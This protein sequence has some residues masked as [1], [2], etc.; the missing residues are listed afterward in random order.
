MTATTAL[1]CVTLAAVLVAMVGWWV[2]GVRRTA[3]RHL[4]RQLTERESEAGAAR[5]DAE[6]LGRELEA[7]RAACDLA[8]QLRLRCGQVTAADILPPVEPAA[9]PTSVTVE[10]GGSSVPRETYSA[11]DGGDID[12]DDPPPGGG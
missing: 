8:D 2:A 7:S 12:L 10:V 9:P 1:V 4:R 6:R 11:E 3:I 5:A